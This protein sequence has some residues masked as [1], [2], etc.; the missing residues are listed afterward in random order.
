LRR[1]QEKN[2]DA[3]R[4]LVIAH[5]LDPERAWMIGNSP[6]SDINPALAAGIGAVYVPHGTY[7][8]PRKG[9]N[10]REPTPAPSREFRWFTQPVLSS[11][12]FF[13]KI[14]FL[15]SIT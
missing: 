3:Y 15:E 10:Y 7:L 13:A 5:E 1:D 4:A 8:D 6:K 11:D 9:R 12:T 14:F 2:V